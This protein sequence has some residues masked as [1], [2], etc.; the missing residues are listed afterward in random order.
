MRTHKMLFKFVF[1]I[2]IG[3]FIFHG[4]V[5]GSALLKGE[6]IYVID[7]NKFNDIETYYTTEYTIDEKTKCITFKNLIGFSKK[8]TVC[9]DYTLTE[10]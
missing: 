2:V 6:K 5:I 8:K 3:I 1:V 4:V 9:N 10:Y 7:V